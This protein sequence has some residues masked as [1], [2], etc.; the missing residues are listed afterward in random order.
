MAFVI[1]IDNTGYRAS[2]K[3][4][5]GYQT[6]RDT[7]AQRHGMLRVI[8]DS[9]GSYLYPATRFKSTRTPK[10]RARKAVA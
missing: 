5:K 6:L 8:D 7:K 3:R 9:G 2:L 1:C 10:Q 4:G